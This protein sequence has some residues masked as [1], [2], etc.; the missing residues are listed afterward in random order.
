MQYRDLSSAYS[1]A[2]IALGV[3]QVISRRLLRVYVVLLLGPLRELL[4]RV[5]IPPAVRLCVAE[6]RLPVLPCL[7]RPLTL[8]T[9]AA[10]TLITAA[11]L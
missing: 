7:P 9:V 1:C 6:P 11:T 4:S 3:S 5:V 2:L 8:S 10:I